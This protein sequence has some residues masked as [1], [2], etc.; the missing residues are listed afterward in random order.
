MH[1]VFNLFGGVGRVGDGA[2]GG[3]GWGAFCGRFNET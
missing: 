1:F 2:G 3:G